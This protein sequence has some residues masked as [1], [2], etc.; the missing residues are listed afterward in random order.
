MNQKVNHQ[1]VR[2][3]RIYIK[4][5]H[6]GEI[7]ATSVGER[8]FFIDEACNKE[9]RF[10]FVIL[11]GVCSFCQCKNINTGRSLILKNELTQVALKDQIDD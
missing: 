2:M 5:L 1:E 8:G 4:C 6:C 10:K 7:K 9:E 11:V 3:P